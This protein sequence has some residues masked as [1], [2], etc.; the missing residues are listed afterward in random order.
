[1]YRPKSRSSRPELCGRSYPVVTG[2]RIHVR[3]PLKYRFT[4]GMTWWKRETL[5]AVPYM[6]PITVREHGRKAVSNQ[7]LGS[8]WKNDV[9]VGMNESPGKHLVLIGGAPITM[10]F[11]TRALPRCRDRWTALNAPRSDAGSTV[12]RR[13]LRVVSQGTFVT[14]K[15]VSRFWAMT[16]SASL[17]RVWVSN[18]RSEGYLRVRGPNLPSRNQAGCTRDNGPDREWRQRSSGQRITDRAWINAGEGHGGT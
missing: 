11:G 2:V 4:N 16:G 17:L 15:R 8:K 6:V 9:A 3:I 18:C 12:S 5:S 1:M 14:L 10:V 7:H 13:F